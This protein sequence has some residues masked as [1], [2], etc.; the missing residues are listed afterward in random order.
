MARAGPTHRGPLWWAAHAA[1]RRL[2]PRAPP[3]PGPPPGQGEAQHKHDPW[4]HPWCVPP[5][6]Q[7]RLDRLPRWWVAAAGRCWA[8]L[9]PGR[10]PRAGSWIRGVPASPPP[11]QRW[12]PQG[13]T[14]PPDPPALVAASS[15]ASWVGSAAVLALVSVACCAI[16]L[17]CSFGGPRGFTSAADAYDSSSGGS[18]ED[19]EEPL[20][21]EEEGEARAPT[22]SARTAA[23]EAAG[24]GGRVAPAHDAKL[25]RVVDD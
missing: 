22:G 16:A 14:H 23:V 5:L 11:P 7:G 25:R 18:S 2:G 13:L 1:A 6:H 19:E 4:C 12:R 10:V 9:L 21:E 3:L 8:A 20:S 24:R 15:S 17:R